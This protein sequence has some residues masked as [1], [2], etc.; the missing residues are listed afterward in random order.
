M[1]IGAVDLAAPKA[2]LTTDE[3]YWACFKKQR[4]TC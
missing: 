2:H 3:G 4:I 1:Y